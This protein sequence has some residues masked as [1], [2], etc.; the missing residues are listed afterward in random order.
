LQLVR[1]SIDTHDWRGD[2][3]QVMFDYARSQI[4]HGGAVLMHDA[5]G[6]G[7]RRAGCQNTL[8]LLP[9]LVALGRAHGLLI[10]P[11]AYHADCRL[12]ATGQRTTG[13]PA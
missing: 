13:A 10:A 11:M 3:P 5:L 6:P 2:E 9:R 8:A 1:W 4:A 7:A 12:S